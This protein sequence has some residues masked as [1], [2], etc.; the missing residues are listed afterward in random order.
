MKNKEL[1]TESAIYWDELPNISSV[2]IK[3]I[4][5]TIL[6]DLIN[7]NFTENNRYKDIDVKL[8]QHI[9]WL[10]DYVRDTFKL[11]TG[12]NL[13]MLNLKAQ[14]HPANETNIK[15]NHIN[16]YDLRNS[17]D[18]TLMYFIESDEN[19]MIVEYEDHRHKEKYWTIPF[20]TN[21]L[22]MFNSDLNYY[23][24]PNTLDKFRIILIINFEIK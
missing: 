8:T 17:P 6:E 1:L 16:S 7:F 19:N 21:K 12:K 15:R 14:I 3:E 5:S 2:N 9:T 24:L 22:I 13:N 4:K 11:K 20:K 18:M 10:S 23:L